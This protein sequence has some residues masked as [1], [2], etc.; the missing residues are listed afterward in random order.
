MPAPA[1]S[2]ID[3]KKVTD[4]QMKAVTD[5]VFGEFKAAG[6]EDRTAKDSK[7]TERLQANWK[8]AATKVWETDIGRCRRNRFC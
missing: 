2:K 5:R 3:P 6:A 1:I 8:A 4:A 7:F